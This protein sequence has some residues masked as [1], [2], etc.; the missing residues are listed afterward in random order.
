MLSIGYLI[1]IE[2]WIGMEFDPYS[3]E[4]FPKIMGGSY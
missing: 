2:Y 4:Q 3:C 1:E